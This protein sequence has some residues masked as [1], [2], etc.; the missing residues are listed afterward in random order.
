METKT[1]IC[2]SLK[3]EFISGFVDTQTYSQH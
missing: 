3:F 2:T 1:G